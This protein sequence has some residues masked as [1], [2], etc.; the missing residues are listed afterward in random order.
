MLIGCLYHKLQ[1]IMA[2]IHYCGPTKWNA[3]SR[4]LYD[5]KI[6]FQFLNAYF[7]VYCTYIG[8]VIIIM[9]YAIYRSQ[10][11]NNFG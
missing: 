9:M 6:L 11:K 1:Q 10:L 8:I 5:V 7:S 3:L 2:Y 4:V